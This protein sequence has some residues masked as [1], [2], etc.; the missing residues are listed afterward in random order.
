MFSRRLSTRLATIAL[1]SATA[2]TLAG[3]GEDTTS[4]ESGSNN[5]QSGA[6]KTLTV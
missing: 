3:C 4:G 6:G 1:A 5:S 2:F